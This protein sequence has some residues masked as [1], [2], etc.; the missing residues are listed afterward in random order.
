M[1]GMTMWLSKVKKKDCFIFLVFYI[2]Q[3]WPRYYSLLLHDLVLLFQFINKYI[4]FIRACTCIYPQATLQP[5]PQFLYFASIY[6]YWFRDME[7]VF[8]YLFQ[9]SLSPCWIP[10]YIYLCT[11]ITGLQPLDLIC[12]NTSGGKDI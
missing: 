11:H 9:P 5:L 8:A 1:K 10:L 2:E 7:R 3:H 12:K 6:I 4:V